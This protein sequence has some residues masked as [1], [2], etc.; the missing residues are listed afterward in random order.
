[1]KAISQPTVATY[2][3]ASQCEYILC[4]SGFIPN[5][6]YYCTRSGFTSARVSSCLTTA[7]MEFE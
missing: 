3:G 6:G 7:Q 1:M 2:N 4:Q 5:C